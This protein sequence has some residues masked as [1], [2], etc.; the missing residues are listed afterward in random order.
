MCVLTKCRLRPYR[1]GGAWVEVEHLE[2]DGIVV[3]HAYGHGGAGFQN[4]IGS[5]N[6]VL[7]LLREIRIPTKAII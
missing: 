2:E 7:R 3:I 1:K 5:A 6:K 4:S